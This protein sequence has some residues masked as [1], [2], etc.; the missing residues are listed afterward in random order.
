MSQPVDEYADA[1]T[2]ADLEAARERI[3]DRLPVTPLFLSPSLSATL[4]LPLYL[5]GE[6][7]QHTG[8]FKPRGALNWVRSA[9]E[10][11]L[12]RGLITV[13]AGNHAQALAWAA[14]D[15][16]AP[17][18]VVMPE[19]SSPMK[20]AATRGF[21]AEVI[22]H[23]AINETLAHMEAL[24]AERN[25]LLVPPYNHPR[26]IAGQGTVGLEIAEQCPQAGLV[27]CPIGGGGLISGIALALKTLRPDVRIVGVEPENAATMRNAWNRGD[28]HARL[29]SA[30]TVAA[31]LGASVVGE[32]TYAM[33]RRY[34]DDIVTVTEAEIIEGL[35]AVMTQGKL[36]AE[37]GACVAV[38]AL[39][40]GRIGTRPGDRV[41]AVITGG[42]LDVEQAKELL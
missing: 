7:F 4:D 29:D 28:M 23:G 39:L 25:L 32:Y 3:R 31:S 30:D 40:A 42:N 9:S 21:G 19:G 37:P 8:S 24:R 16:G 14:R 33:T 1:V 2:F 26:I 12:A 13:S 20:V 6:L 36:Y 15:V 22:L 27:C 41:V 18:T 17:V 34:V 35:R 5:K 38:A 11:E 10:E